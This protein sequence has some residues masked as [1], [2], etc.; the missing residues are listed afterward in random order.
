[1]QGYC[2][3][4]KWTILKRTSP[5]VKCLHPT[6]SR[7]EMCTLSVSNVIYHKFSHGAAFYT[8]NG[9][10]VNVMLEYFICQICFRNELYLR[11][12]RDVFPFGQNTLTVSKIESFQLLQQ[13][14]CHVMFLNTICCTLNVDVSQDNPAMPLTHFSCKKINSIKS[15]KNTMLKNILINNIFCLIKQFSLG[16]LFLSGI[17]EARYM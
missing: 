8:L 1:M 10:N 6:S 16:V 7:R 9:K 12:F 11:R 13:L 14:T 2:D 15:T 5:E 4:Y 3:V 17:N